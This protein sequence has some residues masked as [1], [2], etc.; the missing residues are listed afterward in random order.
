MSVPAI[1][2]MTTQIKTR[3][4]LEVIDKKI[5]INNRINTEL[6]AIAKTLYHYW[7][8]QFDFP[9]ANGK[10]YKTSGG[11]IVYNSILKQEIPAGWH[12]CELKDIIERSGTG[13]NPRNNFKLGCGNNF[14]VTIKISVMV[15]SF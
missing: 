14:Y 13:L 12:D 5:K 2:N 11:K 1:D 4:L 10:P 8:V 9:D 15:K 7:F 6:E 3:E